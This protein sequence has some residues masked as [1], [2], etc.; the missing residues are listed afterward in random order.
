MR[1]GGTDQSGKIGRVLKALAKAFHLIRRQG[2]HIQLGRRESAG[3]ARGERRR[4]EGRGHECHCRVRNGGM[5]RKKMQWILE[6]F[7]EREVGQ[8]I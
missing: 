4:G 1:G 6:H 3:E 5:A 2:G 8:G 7:W